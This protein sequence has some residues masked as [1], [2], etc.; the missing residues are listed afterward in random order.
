M[1]DRGD[2]PAYL[3]LQPE[4]VV[5]RAFAGD[6]R[7][8]VAALIEAGIAEDSLRSECERAARIAQQLPSV[9][10]AYKALAARAVAA[11]RALNTV[12][13]FYNE[14]HDGPE[15]MY[16]PLEER[17]DV[18]DALDEWEPIIAGYETVDLAELGT[19]RQTGDDEL[20][21]RRAALRVAV[22]T[23]SSELK[24]LAQGAPN[25]ERVATLAAALFGEVI[26]AD[27]VRRW[28]KSVEGLPLPVFG[29]WYV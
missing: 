6:G 28:Q 12:R 5:A 2:R 20:S 18:F 7:W 16:R 29:R 15:G 23:L 4:E 22:G 1:L 11:R 24:R 8:A 26:I 9:V 3:D 13:A 17:D 19:R 27:D 10:D 21:R 14:L 25:D